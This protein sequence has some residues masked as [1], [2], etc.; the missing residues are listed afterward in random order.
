MF[1][2]STLLALAA[3]ASL[4]A[5]ELM[6][7][8]TTSTD[9]T[10]LLNVIAPAFKADTGIE[11]KWVAVGTGKALAL[12]KGCDADAV[13]THDPAQEDAFEQAGYGVDR[14]SVMYNDFVI[15]APKSHQ[16]ALAG[17]S[18]AATFDY[19]RK[20]K[21]PFISRGD[22]SGT[23]AK[24]LWLWD[25]TQ[26]G[27]PSAKNDASWYF[28]AGQGMIQSLI[29][30]EERGGMVLT[31][32]GTYI[33]YLDTRKANAKALAIVH[34]GDGALKNPYSIMAVNP[35]NCPNTRYTE[36][37]QFIDWL[38]SEK[39]AQLIREFKLLGQSLFF[40]ER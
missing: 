37:K 32:R 29:M 14:K 7:S 34:E 17:Q 36:A 4:M 22:N 16:K 10:G 28:E 31:D 27:K 3:T 38:T 25:L 15:V 35:K 13:L 12:A 40:V 39:G 19:A 21:L 5:S 30:G 26:A 6:L 1:V 20:N 11:L 2:R 33:K 24:E 8:T 9:N 23:H 18:A